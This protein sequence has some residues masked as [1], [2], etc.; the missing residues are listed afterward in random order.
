MSIH[1]DKLRDALFHFRAN[2]SELTLQRNHQALLFFLSCTR[3]LLFL[4]SKIFPKILQSNASHMREK[5][6]AMSMSSY[7]IITQ[8]ILSAFTSNQGDPN[9]EVT[10]R[11]PHLTRPKLPQTALPFSPMFMNANC[12]FNLGFSVYNDHSPN[13]TKSLLFLLDFLRK[14]DL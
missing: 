3:L 8:Q 7:V 11:S 1:T 4:Y 5:C 14:Y 2:T 12:S 13:T 6:R 9:Q 10:V